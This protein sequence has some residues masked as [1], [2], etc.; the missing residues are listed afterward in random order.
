MIST[1]LFV[2]TLAQAQQIPAVI[3]ADS[4][5]DS[6]T[7]SLVQHA[8]QARLRN[9]RLVTAYR[10]TVSSR[11]G[12]GLKALAR[13]RM[14]YR[15]ELVANIAWRRDS[16]ST[17]TFVGA[18]SAAP[19]A[20][21]GD[22][23]PEG[24]Q[25]DA[26]DLVFDPASD[27]LRVVGTGNSRDGFIY[28]LR[29]GGE[30]DYRFAIGGETK[31]GLPGGRQIRI[32]A[33]KVTP[34]RADWRLIAGTLWFD[35]DTYGLVRAAFRPARPFEMRRDLDP[36]DAKDVP[37]FINFRGEVQFVTIEYA[38]QE[39]RWWMP[40]YVAIDAAGSMG[41]WLNVP[42][43]MERTYQDYAVEGG[44]APDSTSTFRPA[45]RRSRRPQRSMTGAPAR[46]STRGRWASD[47][48]LTVVIP[49]D[50]AALLAASQLGPPIL[51]MGDLISERELR[52]LAGAIDALPERDWDRHVE[53]PSGLSALLQHA[54][55]NRV[56][57]LSLG[58]EAG[59]D[60]GRFRLEALGRI[61]IADGV[62]NG[63]LTL[64]RGTLR[65][66][67]ALGAYRRLV[68]ANPG[69]H[70]LGAVNSVLGLIAGRDDGEYFRT[71]GTE[72][73]ATNLANGWWDARLYYQQERAARVETSASLPH[74][75][76]NTRAFR[77]NIMAQPANQVGAALTLRTSRPLSRA[78]RLGAETTLEGARG[79][80]DFGRGA[81]TLRAFVTPTG[82]FAGAVTLAAGTTTGNVPLQSRF[83]LGG[84]GSLRGYAGG[85]ASG[86]AFWLA[87]AEVGRGIPAARLIAFSDIGWAGDRA[88]FGRDRALAGVGLGASF[89]DGLVRVDLAR[90]L[91]A[92]TG[93]RLEFYVDGAL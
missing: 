14:L 13:D 64:V 45:G 33:L 86:T 70:P 34:R 65:T 43:R 46:D 19:I 58:A 47:S 38:L 54:R 16:V 77:P 24:L 78:L 32:L 59:V 71:L 60:F 75:F 7:A 31:I 22:K 15:E 18:R 89:L 74:L 52:G 29:V 3:P 79:D 40:R 69:E 63:E 80:F 50:S 41:S 66:R 84:A 56:E 90:A 49:A 26:R 37:P 10:A 81:V 51:D 87:R 21:R 1:L 27:Y 68:A 88:R 67:L 8:R 4:Y 83:Y 72:L 39:G 2:A 23:V 17:I 61:G 62:P 85:V 48:N 25:H 55:F 92:P 9:E 53:L 76:D 91:R 42:F 20:E 82:P 5:A 44:T 73:T 30:A 28:P 6:A 12:V 93:W 57:A 11:M 36:D 35:A